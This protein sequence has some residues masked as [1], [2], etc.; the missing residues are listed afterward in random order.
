MFRIIFIWLLVLALLA[1]VVLAGLNLMGVMS[2]SWGTLIAIPF[3]VA[4]LGT[5]AFGLIYLFIKVFVSII[6]P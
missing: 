5:L 4:I 2:L 6:L 3:V 1:D